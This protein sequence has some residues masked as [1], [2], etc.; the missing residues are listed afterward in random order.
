MSRQLTL[1]GLAIVCLT[2]ALELSFRTASYATNSETFRILSRDDYPRAPQNYFKVAIF[3]DSAATGFNAERGFAEIIKAELEGVIDDRPVYLKVF[4][5][6]GANFIGAQ[7]EIAKT[8]IPNFD[9][10]IIYAGNNEYVPLLQAKGFFAR[11]G[12]RVS[13]ELRIAGGKQGRLERLLSQNSVLYSTAYRLI[14]RMRQSVSKRDLHIPD[15]VPFTPEPLLSEQERLEVAERFRGEL[16]TIAHAATSAGKRLLILSVPVALHW[17]PIQTVLRDP[18]SESRL[19]TASGLLKRGKAAMALRQLEA[20]KKAEP[21]AAYLDYLRGIAF[22]RLNQPK[23]ARKLLFE[24]LDK[25]TI[26]IRAPRRFFEDWSEDNPSFLDIAAVFDA[27]AAGPSPGQIFS[28][29]LFIDW[30]HP[31]Q[32]GHTLIARTVL[33]RLTGNSK[34]CEKISG[35]QL[36]RLNTRYTEALK[37]SEVERND[38]AADI[39]RY[40]VTMAPLMPPQHDSIVK[41]ELQRI[42]QWGATAFEAAY[43]LRT[44]NWADSCKLLKKL[45][46]N[47]PGLYRELV[48]DELVIYPPIST[49]LRAIKDKGHA[50]LNDFC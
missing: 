19:T 38:N 13:K 35:T 31:S 18:R 12:G 23:K 11:T 15:R 48:G 34:H 25:D 9:L 1:L 7:A 36:K 33:C 50:S 26:P 20:L 8:E 5:E 30:H 47:A 45:E 21:Q 17:E 4:A 40:Y 42:P 16:K 46:A 2:L 14:E 39:L 3:G 43:K 6:N 27:T 37:V 41:R 29:D 10:L 49:M 24:A 44:G 22:S 28:D 32:L